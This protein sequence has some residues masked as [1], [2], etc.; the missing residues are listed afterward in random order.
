MSHATVVNNTGEQMSMILLLYTCDEARYCTLFVTIFVMVNEQLSTLPEYSVHFF[1]ITSLLRNMFVKFVAVVFIVVHSC[2]FY[3]LIF[4]LY[5]IC[6]VV[7]VV[8]QHHHFALCS[9]SQ[10]TMFPR[11]DC[12][13]MSEHICIC[14]DLFSISSFA[15]SQ[16]ALRPSKY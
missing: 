16:V 10:I 4:H 9:P 12:Q 5:I 6:D 7:H 2:M 3:S 1:S 8:F 15:L 14:W 13:S 11:K